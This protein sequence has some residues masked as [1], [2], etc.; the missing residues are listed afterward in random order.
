MHNLNNS[1]CD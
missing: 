1:W